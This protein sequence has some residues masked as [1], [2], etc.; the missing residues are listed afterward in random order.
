MLSNW[1]HPCSVNQQPVLT[2]NSQYGFALEHDQIYLYRL[3]PRL[4]IC[5]ILDSFF[6]DFDRFWAFCLNWRFPKMGVLLNHPFIDG[7]F[8]YKPSSYWGTPIYGNPHIVILESKFLSKSSQKWEYH[9]TYHVLSTSGWLY[10]ILV[11][12]YVAGVSDVFIF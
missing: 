2:R 6:F 11:L 7:I 9:W 3:V 12:Q 5:L 10:V 8:H 4:A 1:L